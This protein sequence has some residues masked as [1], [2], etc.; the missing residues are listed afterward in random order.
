MPGSRSPEGRG[1]QQQQAKGDN[2]QPSSI[3]P[4]KD[5]TADDEPLPDSGPPTRD[6]DGGQV[7][8]SLLSKGQNSESLLAVSNHPDGPRDD[9]DRAQVKSAAAADVGQMDD[10]VD[11]FGDDSE[12]FLQLVGAM[13]SDDTWVD[14]TVIIISY[15][16]IVLAHS[17]LTTKQ[18][19]IFYKLSVLFFY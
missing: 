17:I 12:D 13:D 6:E 3:D 14:K 11:A 15:I 4:E 19:F 5:G 1:Q 16:Y 8:E 2:C 10:S 18:S 7:S 9:D